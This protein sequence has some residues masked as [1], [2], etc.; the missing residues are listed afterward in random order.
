M[1]ATLAAS[2]PLL[3]GQDWLS[4]FLFGPGHLARA[5]VAAAIY[6]F[7]FNFFGKEVRYRVILSV[8]LHAFLPVFA[9]LLVLAPL[10]SLAS[11]QPPYPDDPAL[12]QLL[13]ALNPLEVWRVIL[14]G[15]G[16]TLALG[17]SRSFATSV[18][19]AAWALQLAVD[20]LIFGRFS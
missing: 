10:F 13:L 20:L 11:F 7:V 5:A 6:L 2:A 9:T 1:L 3:A 15:M 4:G 19:L 18:V 14:T 8:L 12:Q 16:F 17:V